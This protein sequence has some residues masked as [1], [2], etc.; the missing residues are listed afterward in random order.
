MISSLRSLCYFKVVI[1]KIGRVLKSFPFLM[2]LNRG[3][4]KIDLE[5]KWGKIMSTQY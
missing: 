1:D 2:I 5:K 4:V 3:V